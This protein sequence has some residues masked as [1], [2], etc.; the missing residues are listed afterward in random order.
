MAGKSARQTRNE[1]QSRTASINLR[2]EPSTRDLIDAAAGVL[3]KSRTEF[4]LDSARRD[5]VDTL[6]DQRL[7]VL[8]ADRFDA[9]VEA[10]DRPPAPNSKLKSLMKRRPA[11]DR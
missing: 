6:L 11:W 7:F 4:M 1:G 5:A 8:E 10:L 9:F 2:I 3:G